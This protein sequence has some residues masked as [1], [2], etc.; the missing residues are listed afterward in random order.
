MIRIT[1]REKPSCLM[2]FLHG[3]P[4]SFISR[5]HTLQGNLVGRG[6]IE[7][8]DGAPPVSAFLIT[9]MKNS[10]TLLSTDST[11]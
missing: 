2:S 5:S 9:G 11:F 4:S 6:A 1:L 3:F 8:C 7:F 10:E